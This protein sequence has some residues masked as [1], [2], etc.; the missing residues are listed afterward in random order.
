MSE[1]FT[2][3]AVGAGNTIWVAGSG[4]DPADETV[5]LWF[6]ARMKADGQLDWHRSYR[7]PANLTAAS[8][9]SYLQ[10]VI[11]APN[12]GALLAANSYVLTPQGNRIQSMMLVRTDS[13]GNL[14]WERTRSHLRFE[15]CQKLLP[16]PDGLVRLLGL[17]TQ[18]NGVNDGRVLTLPSYLVTVTADNVACTGE[19]MTITITP[20]S[21]PTSTTYN[22]ELLDAAGS[23][24]NPILL[25]VRRW[26]GDTIVQIPAGV[27]T[28]AGFRIRLTSDQFAEIR[29]LTAPFR[30]LSRP[31]LNHL[32]ISPGYGDAGQPVSLTGLVE[33]LVVGYPYSIT[34][35]NGVDTYLAGPSS[36]SALQLIVNP[37]RSGSFTVTAQTLFR[38]LVVEKSPEFNV[39]S[40]TYVTPTGAGQQKGRSWTDALPGSVL[41]QTVSAA[42]PGTRVRVA[43]G[44]YKP[45][46]LVDRTASF[47]VA[48]GVSLYGGFVGTETSLGQR[49]VTSPSSTTLSGDI[50][51]VNSIT[52][53]AYHVVRLI[54]NPNQTQLNNLV[55]TG[56]NATSSDEV[57]SNE[58]EGI[59]FINS[60]AVIVNCLITANRVYFGA[61]VRI[62]TS[63]GATSTPSFKECT[64]QNN[65][66]PDGGLGGGFYI[67]GSGSKTTL[68]NCLITNNL[69]NYK[70]GGFYFSECAT[71][72]LNCRVTNNQAQMGAAL[73]SDV[74]F[75]SCQPTFINCLIAGNSAS[76]AGGVVNNDGYGSVGIACITSFINCTLFGNRAYNGAISSS[77]GY[78]SDGNRI[79]MK[80][81]IVWGHTTALWVNL[82]ITQFFIDYSNVQGGTG[83]VTT[84]PLF[85]NAAN[86]DFRLRTTSPL[87]NAGDPLSTTQ[88]VSATDLDGY[89]RLKGNRIDLGA[90]EQQS[91]LIQSA[92]HGSWLN[93]ATWTCQ[94]LPGAGDQV[95]IR[96][97]VSVPVLQ[98]IPIRQLRFTATGTLVYGNRSRVMPTQ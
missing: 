44:L 22:A 96:H 25:I 17:V 26:A 86:N 32:S 87:I 72:L 67:S 23:F 12:G 54:G 70:G 11:A 64:I 47:S 68:L 48:S 83:N 79:Y 42:R 84:D 95:L 41:A 62:N 57:G 56:G 38:C 85:V 93:A 35:T 74:T 73:T 58:E 15:H 37:T 8:S 27:G 51:V 75:S 30:V 52:D 63:S 97:N 77:S 43:G 89:V 24:A 7:Q 19:T 59:Q 16:G 31:A 18:T 69:G 53:N 21:Q 36:A 60:N 3:V 45:T 66:A 81:S 49:P 71:T 29:P 92:Q 5:P 1:V 4:T 20:D 78:R 91:S 40:I 82:S 90:Y 88:T 6:Y 80:N 61:G 13:A 28:G 65:V 55:I 94:C 9:A 98:T 14:V 50:G 46:T 34:A 2:S 76:N 10:S 33:G 39:F